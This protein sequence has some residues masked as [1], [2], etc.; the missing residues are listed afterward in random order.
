MTPP[1]T[2]DD[3]SWRTLFD[4]YA[5]SWTRHLRGDN[6]ST[7]TIAIYTYATKQLFDYCGQLPAGAAVDGLARPETIGDITRGHIQGLL[8]DK[9]A[10]TWSPAMAHQCYR[11][12]RVFFSYLVEEEEIDRSPMAKMKGPIVP[13]VPVPILTDDQIIA[14]LATCQGRDFVQLRDTAI[15]RLLM[16]TGGRRQEIGNLLVA[17]ID[18][19]MDTITV[20]GKGRIRRTIPFAARTGQALDRYLRVRG[21][22]RHARLP[23]LWLAVKRD[24][25]LSPSGM[26][27]MLD[28]RAAEAGIGKIFPHRFRHTMAHAWMAGGGEGGDLDRIMGWRSGE[29]MRKRYGASLADERAQTAA[30]RLRLGDRI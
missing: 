15:I 16:D 26:A 6:K 3:G 23:E 12:L 10:S 21:R 8:G 11:S 29:E 17:D 4:S 7:R 9:M 1:P 24:T 22:Q 13:A 27:Q 30:R 25:P 18:M 20:L 5:R 2:D 14:L 19:D 28:R